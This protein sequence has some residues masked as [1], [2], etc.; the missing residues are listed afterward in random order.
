MPTDLLRPPPHAVATAVGGAFSDLGRPLLVGAYRDVRRARPKP[1][2][3]D[4]ARTT[5]DPTRPGAIENPY[6]HLAQIREHAVVINE[7]LGVWMMGRYGDV[8]AA[9]RNNETFSSAEAVLLR[10]FPVKAA[11]ATDPPDHT[12][13]RRIAQPMFTSKAVHKLTSD[14]R[15]LA[16]EGVAVMK[17]GDVVDLVPALTVPLPVTIIA[18][19]LGIP[20]DQ[21]PAFRVVSD[22]FAQLFSPRTFSEFARWFADSVGAYLKLRSFVDAELDRRAVHPMNDLLSRLR[23]ALDSGELDDQEAFYYVLMVLVAGNETTTNL[24]GILLV[25]LAQDREL[26]AA[27]KAERG[28]LRAA[29]EEAARWGSPVQ[30][31]TRIATAPHQVGQTVIPRGGRVVLFYASANRD[32]DKFADPNRFDVHRD[33]GGHIAFGHGVHFC[34]GAHLARLEVATA[35]DHLLDEVD[36]IELAGPV[37]WATT[38]S[39]RGP[40]SVPVRI[41]G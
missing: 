34:L 5:F 10:S 12:R 30:W 33:T 41:A 29:V 24:L 2:T 15:H 26:F 39:L 32:P 21:W 16:A 19:I 9:A 28:L 7:R 40:A 20:R 17:R 3:A 22:K 13:L 4:V 27:L 18:Q 1:A 14:I 11:I 25:R 35:I 23:T 38:P 8:H 6:A 36:G 37:R 31:V